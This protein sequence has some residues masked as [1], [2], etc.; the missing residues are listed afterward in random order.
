VKAALFVT[1]VNDELF[2]ETPKAV[3]KILERLDR[4]VVVTCE[5][6]GKQS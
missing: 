3:V 2:P 6:F 1:C 5:Q 4:E